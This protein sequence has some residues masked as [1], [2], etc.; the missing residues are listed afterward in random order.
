MIEPTFQILVERCQ[1]PIQLVDGGTVGLRHL[2]VSFGGAADPMALGYTNH[3]LGKPTH[4][5]ALEIRFGQCELRFEQA[6]LIALGGADAKARLNGKLLDNWQCVAVK[7]GDNLQLSMP[8]FGVYT[9]LAMAADFS[10]IANSDNYQTGDAI[11]YT[12]TQS[13]AR[14]PLPISLR[15]DY[16]GNLTLKLIPAQSFN[17]LTPANLASLLNV[18]AQLMGDSNTMGVRVDSELDAKL[19]PLMRSI[20]TLPGSVQLPP[21]GNPIVLLKDCQ[22]IGG[23]PQIGRVHALQLG[24]LAQRR[25][26]QKLRWQ[27]A[28]CQQEWRA[29]RKWRNWLAS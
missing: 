11:K 7:S 14:G 24:L 20:P 16:A 17:Q 26:G 1:A 5:C 4:S 3:L 6:G 12:P 15:P 9:Y 10:G 23:Y 13:S 8:Q 19:M 29:W 28:S 21:D 27:L 2:G 22:T 18:E 25:P